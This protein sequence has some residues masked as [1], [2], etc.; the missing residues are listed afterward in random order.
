MPELLSVHGRCPRCSQV[1]TVP[2][3][4]LQSVFRCAR[5][6]YRVPGTLLVD[7][8][9]T[10]PPKWGSNH[11]APVLGPLD[12]DSDDQHTRVLMPGGPDDES[13][14]PLAAVL[15]PDGSVSSH[16]PPGAP[17]QRFETESAEGDDQQTRMHVPGSFDL[18]A[19]AA[20]LVR[21]APPGG[22]ARRR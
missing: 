14:L 10:S 13:E 15:V 19:A 8:A 4:Q 20:P 16:P 22:T 1:L 2:A 3:G 5:C 6:Q 18:P 11:E 7:E 9:R 17:L 12:E 21:S